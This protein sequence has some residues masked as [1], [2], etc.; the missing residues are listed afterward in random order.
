MVEPYVQRLIIDVNVSAFF[1]DIT[2]LSDDWTRNLHE[3][4]CKQMQMN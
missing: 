3:T 4:V 2:N 1:T